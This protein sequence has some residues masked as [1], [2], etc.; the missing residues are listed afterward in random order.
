MGGKVL[1]EGIVACSCFFY[2]FIQLFFVAFADLLAELLHVTFVIAIALKVV[3]LASGKVKL[4]EEL[5]AEK[6]VPTFLLILVVYHSN[7]SLIKKRKGRN[8]IMV[9]A[10]SQYNNLHYEE[11]LLVFIL[12]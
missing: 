12:S 10:S 7:K 9:P 6:A 2:Y 1:I 3:L 5:L 8:K 4:G 11:I